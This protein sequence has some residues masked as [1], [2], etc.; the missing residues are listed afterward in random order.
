M[1]GPSVWNQALRF[2][3]GNWRISILLLVP[4]AV[5]LEIFHAHPVAI[6][7]VARWRSFPWRAFWALPPRN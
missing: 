1:A 5:L 3:L 6:F 2:S 4:G 7:G